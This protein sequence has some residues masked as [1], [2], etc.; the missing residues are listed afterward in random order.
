MP[1]CLV[2]NCET[3]RGLLYF[4]LLSPLSRDQI[5]FDPHQQW[6]P[7][8]SWYHLRTWNPSVLRLTVPTPPLEPSSLSNYLERRNGTQ[9][10][11]TASPCLQWNGITRSMTRR[12]LLSSA[13]WKSGGISWKK[14]GTWYRFE[15][16]TK[17]W[18]ISWWLRNSTIV[19]LYSHLGSKR[20][21]FHLNNENNQLE[22]R[23]RP[24]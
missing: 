22:R 8:W 7:L 1:T 3:S 16:T 13:H 21:I 9:W 6:P 19:T 14:P 17:T 15:R 2:Y 4:H 18:S 24:P 20:D 10:P 23:V 11:S 5:P 12:C